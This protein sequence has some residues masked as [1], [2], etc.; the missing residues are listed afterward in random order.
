MRQ[1]NMKKNMTI[2][3]K[4]CGKDNFFYRE[5]LNDIKTGRFRFVATDPN[6]KDAAKIAECV[7]AMVE[8][9]IEEALK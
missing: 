7:T 1:N 8:I 9:S 6:D 4:G 2:T 5:L 3:G